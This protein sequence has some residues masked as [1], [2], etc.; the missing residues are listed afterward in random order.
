MDG[1]DKK[2]LELSK[3]RKGLWKNMLAMLK[4]GQYYGLQRVLEDGI[5]MFSEEERCLE[6][7]KN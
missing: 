5:K 7:S 6:K 4:Q 3:S 1:F 2:M